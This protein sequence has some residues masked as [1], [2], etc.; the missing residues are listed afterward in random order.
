MSKA[1]EDYYSY[2]PIQGIIT[3]TS[4]GDASGSIMLYAND[5]FGRAYPATPIIFYTSESLEINQF[6]VYPNPYSPSLAQEKVYFGFSITQPAE[7]EIRIFDAMGREVTV[8][9]K[10]TFPQGQHSHPTDGWN[11]TLSTYGRYLSAGTYYIK[12]IATDIETGAKEVAT[13]KWAVY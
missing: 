5:H 8:V 10:Q 1:T 4:V 13:T 6:M 3:I 2:D 11:A 9:P 12:L 7:I